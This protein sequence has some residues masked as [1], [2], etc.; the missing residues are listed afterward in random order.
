MWLVSGPDKHRALG[1]LLA[2]DPSIPAS[3]VEARRSVILADAPSSDARSRRGRPTSEERDVT[4]TRIRLM[5]T[6]M[7]GTLVTSV[8]GLTGRAIQ[9]VRRLRN[10]GIR[11]SVTGGRLPRGMAM[12]VEPL[13]LEDPIAG[14]NG[15]VITD[16]GMTV[17]QQRLIPEDLVLPVTGLM[18]SSGLDVWVYR[19]ADWYVPDPDGPHVAREAWTVRF[20]PKVMTR[21]EDLADHGFAK[22]V[23]RYVV[24]DVTA[25]RS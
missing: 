10:A 25:T 1:N 21:I 16:P 9:A 4:A 15:G 2:D 5:L 17:L 19:G 23:E 7:D 11:F 13:A 3:N 12:L 24:A 6:D 20:E 8:K 18:R 22:A 14:F